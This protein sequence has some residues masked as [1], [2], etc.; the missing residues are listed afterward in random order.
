MKVDICPMSNLTASCGDS[1]DIRPAA[2]SIRRWQ[3]K[4]FVTVET[5]TIW[6]LETVAQYGGCDH[7]ASD[8]YPASGDQFG[9]DCYDRS[10]RTHYYLQ[11]GHGKE[12]GYDRD[13]GSDRYGCGGTTC[14]EGENYSDRIGSVRHSKF[15]FGNN[16]S[17]VQLIRQNIYSCC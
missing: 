6:I 7:Y 16:Y 4:V 10:H 15:P 2:L 12:K 13:D 1:L 5:E 9:S 11:N 17:C 14:S 3:W 8:R